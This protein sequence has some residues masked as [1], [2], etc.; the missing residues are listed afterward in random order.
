MLRSLY[1]AVSGVKAHQ[2]YLDVT[3]NNI[4]N[5]NT[6][7][8]KRD[9]TQFRDMI[10][11][12]MKNPSAPDSGV[13]IGGINPAQVGLGVSVGSIET[14]HTQGAL[15]N[16]GIPTDMAISGAGYFV[17]QNG[18]Q[19]LY[20]RAGNF[21]L[22]RD[23][24]LVMSG[25]GY[26]VQGYTYKNQVDPATGELTRV[27]DSSLSDITIKIQEKIPAKATALVNFRSNLCSTSEP[28][29]KDLNSI[30]GGVNKVLRPHDYTAYGSSEVTFIGTAAPTTG[31][32]NGDTFFNTSS[33]ELQ[34][35]NGATAAWD[36]ATKAENTY[37]YGK[38]TAAAGAGVFA[39]IY[40]DGTTTGTGPVVTSRVIV[41]ESGSGVPT[42]PTPPAT[43]TPGR[44]Y[45]DTASGNLY[46]ANSTGTAWETDGAMQ[47]GVGYAIKGGANIYLLDN[48]TTPAPA[49]VTPSAQVLDSTNG[50][51]NVFSWD[52]TEW[53]NQNASSALFASGS[54]TTSQS[55]I[56]AFGESMIKSSDHEDKFTVYDSLG[57]P[58]TMVLKFRKVLDKTA[59]P[60]AT[61]PT[62]AEAEWDWYAYYVDSDGSVMPQY[63]Q[64]AGTMVFGDDGLLK[65]TYYYEPTPAVPDPNATATTAPVYNWSVVEKVIG[66]PS[67]DSVSTGKVVAD[68]NVSGGQ[69]SVQDTTPPTYKSNLITLDFLGQ[70]YAKLNGLT[71]GDPIG[72]ATQFGSSSTLK[73]NGQDGYPMGILEDFSVSQTGLITGAYSNGR[74]LPI[75]QV[76]LAMFAN[77][78][79]LNKVGDSCFAESI[80]SGIAQIGSPQTGGA[81]AIVGNTIEMSNVDLSEE[82]VNLI[83]AQRGFQANTRVVT[84][85]DQ[86]LEEL[87]NL[88]R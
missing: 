73:I 54:S 22:D 6:V 1:A 28:E 65:R 82:F 14:V 17:V 25:N 62:G 71:G 42:P 26:R 10:Y 51:K 70:E 8:F 72:G 5:V 13:P 11:Q 76:A 39:N 59:Q 45:L 7:G 87:I 37:Y 57:N 34:T 9:V 67:Y 15:Q 74:T 81:G 68:F 40:S 52:G 18:T 63:G 75:A 83:R 64:G 35:Y 21:A 61:P 44:T 24:N 2:T 48:Q 41:D 29:I 49:L 36:P 30:P 53:R 33:G 69:G 80:N 47:A 60:T 78:Q 12:T 55:T 43:L 27:K 79:G 32:I 85:S 58:Y 31:M 46:K 56:T 3:G 66:D 4:A 88:K 16:T 23:G 84:T 20:T 19:K 77:S 38:N 86:V 50:S